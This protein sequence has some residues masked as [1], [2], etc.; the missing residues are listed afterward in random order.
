MTEPMGNEENDKEGEAVAGNSDEDPIIQLSEEELAELV[1]PEKTEQDI[2]E[3]EE[4]MKIKASPAFPFGPLVIPA[5]QRILE[6][7]LELMG[8]GSSGMK[9][10]SEQRANIEL[11]IKMYRS[12]ELPCLKGPPETTYVAICDGRAYD[13]FPTKEERQNKQVWVEVGL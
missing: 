11:L 7:T 5:E 3:R 8:T 13:H 9:W 2:A 12:R 10:S 6:L 4:R 1:E